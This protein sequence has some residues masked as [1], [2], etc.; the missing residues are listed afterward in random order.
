MW[1]AG[2]GAITNRK[3]KVALEYLRNRSDAVHS[4]GGESPT[5]PQL[6]P[7]VTEIVGFLLPWKVEAMP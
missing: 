4:L 3:N 6:E 1:E 5:G 7:Q 2:G